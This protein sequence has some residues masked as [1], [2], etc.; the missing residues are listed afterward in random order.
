[1]QG[2]QSTMRLATG[3]WG[4]RDYSLLLRTLVAATPVSS[5]GWSQMVVGP[6]KPGGLAH[7]SL[8]HSSLAVLSQVADNNCQMVLLWSNKLSP[9]QG[10]T[11]SSREAEDWAKHTSLEKIRSSYWTNKAPR[12]SAK[13]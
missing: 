9:K 6:G 4:G 11:P 1:L 13:G 7:R 2:F 8:W 3:G 10:G 5:L 12:G